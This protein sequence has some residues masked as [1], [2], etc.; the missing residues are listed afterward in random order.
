[1]KT[2][3]S[4]RI[5][6]TTDDLSFGYYCAAEDKW[7]EVDAGSQTSIDDAAEALRC[8]SELVE[9]IALFADDISQKVGGDLRDIWLRLDS[10]NLT[11][12]NPA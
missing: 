10:M 6:A 9:A 1:M 2:K 4:V 12:D 11:N 5:T 7:V 3:K 8:P